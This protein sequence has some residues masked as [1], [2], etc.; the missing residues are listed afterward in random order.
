MKVFDNSWRTFAVRAV[1]L[2]GVVF[3]A[4]RLAGARE[5]VPGGPVRS[6]VTVAGTLTGLASGL[7]PHLTFT[8][9]NVQPGTSPCVVAVPA[10]MLAYSPSTNAF[11][12]QVP[13]ATCSPT[14]FDGA[15]VTVA[16]DVREGTMTGRVLLTVPP[17]PIN[18]VPYAHFASIAGQYGT[19][20]CPVGYERAT[21]AAFTGDMRLCQRRR[22][23]GTIYD[24]V[25][26][27]GTGASAFWIDR[28]EASVWEGPDGTG[29]RYSGVGVGV[30]PASRFPANGQWTA[31]LFALSTPS[32]PTVGIVPSVNITWFQ[33]QEAC[34]ASGKRLPTGDEW[35]SGARGTP[36]PEMTLGDGREGRCRTNVAGLGETGRRAPGLGIIGCQSAWGAQDMIGNLNEW[37][38]EWFAGAGSGLSAPPILPAQINLGVQNWGDDYRGDGTS[39]VNGIVGVRSGVTGVGIPAAAFRGGSWGSREQAG[40]FSINLSSAPSWASSDVGFRCVIPR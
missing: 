14:L 17:A 24:E 3:G 37:T 26:R 11:S 8:F 19:P 15:N 13:I 10:E 27:V 32:S 2:G 40:V 36:D 25:V 39:N 6:F 34:R 16:V 23:D 31:P 7:N 20:D 38:A 30:Y 21:D 5:G 28:H 4:V 9:Q 33:A 18:P 1:V 29:T 35:L 12:A 22:S